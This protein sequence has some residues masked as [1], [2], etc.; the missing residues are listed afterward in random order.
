MQTLG[1]MFFILL[2]SPEGST[3][4]C[5]AVCGKFIKLFENFYQHIN[6]AHS[7][8]LLHSNIITGVV[9]Y[10]GYLHILISMPDGIMD[11]YLPLVI[12]ILLK[13]IEYGLNKYQFKSF[14]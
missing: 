5:T 13:K 10:N 12:T 11:L 4:K 3:V 8:R 9:E 1:G 7:F 14:R 2:L 6:A